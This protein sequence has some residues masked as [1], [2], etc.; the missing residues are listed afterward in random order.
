MS[1]QKKTIWLELILVILVNAVLIYVFIEMDLFERVYHFSRD[2][3]SLQLDELI[4]LSIS[5]LLSCIYL[6]GRLWRNSVIYARET[7]A[8]ASKDSLTKLLNR[9]TL[10]RALACEWDRYQRYHENFCVVLFDI[11]DFSDINDALGHVE[12]DRVLIDVAKIVA[13]NTRKTDSVGRWGEEE[14]LILCP[15][16]TTEQATAIAEK[17]R[18]AIYRTLKDG[19][20]LSASFA[21]AQS[22]P[23]GTLE[24]LMKRTDLA[25]HKAKKRGK[26][27]V[28]TG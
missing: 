25:L 9:R 1:V 18:A 2:Y 13:N 6:L 27:C 26:N 28:V 16:C 8:Q 14:F 5:L 10:E 22:H 3:E 21:V 11:D 19:V 15:V 17:L 23:D 7:E 24:E 4:P 12:G 20:E